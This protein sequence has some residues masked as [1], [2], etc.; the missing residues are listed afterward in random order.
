MV[1][2]LIACSYTFEWVVLD[3]FL[4][5]TPC[6]SVVFPRGISSGQ[7]LSDFPTPLT[8]LFAMPG[9]I[10]PQER[11]ICQLRDTF[12]KDIL[13][14]RY[15]RVVVV[16]LHLQIVVKLHSSFPSTPVEKC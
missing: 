10:W 1:Y 8:V 15:P 5:G 3:L 9:L 4:Y 11:M 2:L 14:G 7:Y 6:N 12:P 13:S 16:C